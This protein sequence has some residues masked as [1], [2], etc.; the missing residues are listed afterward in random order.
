MNLQR[1]IGESDITDYLLTKFEVSGVSHLTLGTW[2][3]E[4]KKSLN[5]LTCSTAGKREF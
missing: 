2:K 3:K 1:D 5:A 4:E